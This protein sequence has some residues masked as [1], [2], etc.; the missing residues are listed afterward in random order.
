MQ[1]CRLF[2]FES[3]KTILELCLESQ[4]NQGNQGILLLTLD[5]FFKRGNVKDLILNLNL[6]KSPN[7]Y[8]TWMLLQHQKSSYLKQV[9]PIR[10][11]RKS[12]LYQGFNLAL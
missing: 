1:K 4:T 3:Y 12:M 9:I 5:S 2:H 7:P 11:T 6:T 8:K 10:K